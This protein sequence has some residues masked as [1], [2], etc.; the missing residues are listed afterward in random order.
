MKRTQEG[1][2]LGH[3]PSGLGEGEQWDKKRRRDKEMSDV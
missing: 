1:I 3:K 2:G